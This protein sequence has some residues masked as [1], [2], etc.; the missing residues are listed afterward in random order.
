M[1]MGPEMM[2]GYWSAWHWIFF[3]LFV[4]LVAYPVGRILNRMGFSPLWSVL[5]FIPVINVAALWVVALSDWP[6]DRNKAA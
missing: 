1:M 2:F 6:R 4:G 5:A 3:V